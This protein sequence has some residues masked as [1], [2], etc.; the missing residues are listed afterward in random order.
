MPAPSSC[1]IKLSASDLCF[2]QME[3]NAVQ[4]LAH[5]ELAAQP[6]V[7][8]GRLR[9]TRQHFLLRSGDRRE[10]IQPGRIDFHMASRAGASA[11]ALRDDAVDVGR[12]RAIMLQP[13]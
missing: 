5:D 10:F 9:R 4:V 6:A 3:F 13:V 2:R 7:A 12:P 11:A 1:P 8:P